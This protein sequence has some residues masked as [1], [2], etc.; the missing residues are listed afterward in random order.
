MLR[1][2]F[3][4]ATNNGQS[5]RKSRILDRMLALE[6]AYGEYQSNVRQVWKAVSTS[7]YRLRVD[8]IGYDIWDGEVNEVFE[9]R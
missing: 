8:R 3:S 1:S 4:E 5:C 7:E 9:M 6:E 2:G